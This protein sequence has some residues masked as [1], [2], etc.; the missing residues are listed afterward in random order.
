MARILCANKAPMGSVEIYNSPVLWQN[1]EDVLVVDKEL[2]T[3]EVR[4]GAL[5]IT[6]WEKLGFMDYVSSWK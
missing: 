6:D 3:R 2:S 4:K 5:T 1:S